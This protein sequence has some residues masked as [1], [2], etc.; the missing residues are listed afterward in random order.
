[1]LRE[2]K[3]RELRLRHEHQEDQRR[4]IETAERVIKRANEEERKTGMDQLATVVP[5]GKTSNLNND[6]DLIDGS[7]VQAIGADRM[8]K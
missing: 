8:L 5:S 7:K 3:L 6:Y 4:R 1:M 2:V